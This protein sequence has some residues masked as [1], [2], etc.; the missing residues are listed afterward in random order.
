MSGL[1]LFFAKLFLLVLLF[2]S[3]LVIYQVFGVAQL[4]RLSR[5]TAIFS[6]TYVA[7]IYAFM[8]IYGDFDIVNQRKENLMFSLF[9]SSVMT[10]VIVYVSQC[11]MEKRMITLLCP[12]LIAAVQAV[13]IVALVY[14]TNTIYFLRVPPARSLFVYGDP[15]MLALHL[16]KLSRAKKS[17]A[18]LEQIHYSEG[19]EVIRRAMRR[20]DA[21]FLAD[22]P[23]E[24]ERELMDYAYKHNKQTVVFPALTDIVMNKARVIMFNDTPTLSCR[25]PGLRF[26]QKLVKRFMDILLSLVGLI[27]SSPIFLA[28]C[29]MIKLYDRGPIFFTQDRATINGKVFRLYKF[30]TMVENAEAMGVIPAGEKDPR[31][32]PVGRI[33]RAT[34]MDELPQLLNILKGDMSVVGPRPERVEHVQKYTEELPEF[35]YRLKVKAGLTGF[36][37]IYGKYNTTPKDKLALDLIYIENYSVWMDLKIIFQTLKIIFM[38]ESTEGFDSSRQEEIRETTEKVED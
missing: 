38:S 24:R 20:C 3:A 17:Y 26:E 10:N 28:E 7:S 13:I 31:I 30:R 14:L 16:S 19:D 18:V 32:T 6:I 15:D 37:Q 22:L 2:F 25:Q 4:H 29:L 23:P 1:L 35:R 11:V 9:I 34:R 8:K 27:L 5:H 36:A 21:V 12:L 33:L